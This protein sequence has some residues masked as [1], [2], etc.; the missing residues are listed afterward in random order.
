ME[1]R[2]TYSNIFHN[3]DT[4]DARVHKVLQ[5]VEMALLPKLSP[6]NCRIIVTRLIDFNPDG[7][8]F[9]DVLGV[10]SM[11]SDANLITSD[12]VTK[13]YLADGEILIYDSNGVTPKHLSK[14]GFS[15][16]R[17]FFRYMI[18]AHPMRIK[19]IHIINVSSLLDKIIMLIKPF[20]GSK[21][22][23]IMQFHAPGSETLFDFIPRE[24]L[25]VELNGNDESIEI[26]NK[27]WIKRTE[28]CREYLLND[29]IW[30]LKEPDDSENMSFE[31]SFA[32]MGFC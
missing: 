14:L 29:D 30:T 26:C 18:E 4:T 8:V 7:I 12:D 20:I 11:L 24:I 21:V 9:E 15:L 1:I 23:N 6:D 16:M 10:T 27:N 19:Q 28:D 32:Y 22:M 31:D 5:H 13:N 17:G 2:K 3:R 25:P